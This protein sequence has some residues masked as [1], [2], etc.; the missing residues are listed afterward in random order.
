MDSTVARVGQNPNQAILRDGAT[1]PPVFEVFS[2]PIVRQLVVNMPFVK[3][4]NEYVD[5][6]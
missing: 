6:E 1:G 5:V 3:Q 4:G 2:Q